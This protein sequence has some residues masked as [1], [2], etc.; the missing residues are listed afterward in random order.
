M[1]TSTIQTTAELVTTCIPSVPGA[2][3]WSYATSRCTS[4]PA[5]KGCS[6]GPTTRSGRSTGCPCNCARARPWAWSA[7][8]AGN[9]TTGRL[10]TRLLEP[11]GGQILYQGTDIAHLKEKELRPYRRELQLIFQIRTVA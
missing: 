9:T 6:A 4:V 11:T 1:T 8:P 5:A 3:C 7:S 2:P 10:I